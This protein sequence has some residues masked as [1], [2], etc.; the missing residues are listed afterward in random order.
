[1]KYKLSRPF[2]IVSTI[3]LAFAVGCQSGETEQPQG[4]SSASKE[5]AVSKSETVSE[6][7]TQTAQSGPTERINE[8]DPRSNDANQTDQNEATLASQSERVNET[9][10]M[11]IL[12]WNIESEGSDPRVIA[13][14]LTAMRQYDIYALTEFLPAAEKLFS[15]TL[16]ENFQ[17]IVSRSGRNDRLAI[18]FDV[19]LFELIKVFEIQE[20]NY[21]NRYRAPLVVEL[22]EKKTGLEFQIMNNHLAR[23]KPQVREAQAQQLV[24]WARAQLLP[25]VAVGDYNLDY[26]FAT[27]KGNSAFALMMKDDVWK[28]IKPVEMIDSNW[29]DNPRAPDGLDDY[30]GSLLDFALVSGPAKAWKSRCEIIVRPGDFPD[31]ETTSDHR[32]FELILSN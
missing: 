8:R 32:P 27:E 26:V 1:M 14:E 29:Y 22:K 4:G 23:G 6:T 12:C 2:Y 19:R 17:L 20:I 5:S 18:A 15:D 10:S 21:R 3:A 25:T 24:T 16:G 30:P 13:K 11:K 9:F 7:K 28:W 31:D